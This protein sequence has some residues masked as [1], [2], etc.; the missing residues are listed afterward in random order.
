MLC[1]FSGATSH[2]QQGVWGKKLNKV[3][4][5]LDNTS[6]TCDIK[7]SEQTKSGAVK[8]ILFL[9]Y[10]RDSAHKPSSGLEGYRCTYVPLIQTWT[11]F[12]LANNQ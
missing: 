3:T 5:F 8:V 6:N 4:L 10:Q 7:G 11:K 12:K 9:F 2:D 1:N